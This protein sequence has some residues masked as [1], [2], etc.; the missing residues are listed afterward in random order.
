ME[1]GASGVSLYF[2]SSI[3]SRVS[4]FMTAISFV[5]LFIVKSPN[6]RSPKES[7]SI[8][9]SPIPHARCVW[10]R[11]LFTVYYVGAVIHS[12]SPQPAINT[13]VLYTL[14]AL[15]PAPRLLSCW[16]RPSQLILP[17]PP[18]PSPSPL[19]VNNQPFLSSSQQARYTH[20]WKCT[21]CTTENS[22]Q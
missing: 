6:F 4:P 7:S 12:Q 9:F 2:S 16:T 19:R 20:S 11:N 8:S 14:Q 10:P 18:L 22:K 15:F 3:P 13:R 5:G 17:S 21:A 1:R